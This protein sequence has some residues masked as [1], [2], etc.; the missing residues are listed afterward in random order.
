MTV[1][2]KISAGT[3]SARAAVAVAM[4]ALPPEAA[5]TPAAGMRLASSRLN[6]PRALK[7]PET[8][9]CS[10]FSQTSKCGAGQAEFAAAQHPQRRAPHVRRDARRRGLDVGGRD[11]T[12]STISAMPWPTPM[13]IVHSA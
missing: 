8:C 1:G 2:T 13:H 10:S 6:M 5:I 3:P 7:L 12:R 4:P 11:H 9:N